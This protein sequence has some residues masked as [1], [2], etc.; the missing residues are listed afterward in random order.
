MFGFVRFA[1]FYKRRNNCDGSVV[2]AKFV[3]FCNTE[4]Y[5][6]CRDRAFVTV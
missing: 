3:R 4:S 6:L 1:L 2:E 5:R